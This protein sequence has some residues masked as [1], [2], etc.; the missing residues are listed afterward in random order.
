LK[1]AAVFWVI[2]TGSIFF[3]V[4]REISG[5]WSQ[6]LLQFYLHTH[7]WFSDGKN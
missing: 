3:S 7:Q 5:I 1:S 4:S 6:R 2:V